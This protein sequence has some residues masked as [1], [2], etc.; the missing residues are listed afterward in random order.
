MQ[1]HSLQQFP[2]KVFLPT[3]FS[4]YLRNM[5]A[6]INLVCTRC[7]DDNHMALQRWYNDH[8]QL[9]MVSSELRAAALLRLDQTTASIN[10]LCLYQFADLAEF[11]AFDSGDVMRQVRDLSNAALGRSSVEIIKRTQYKRV[12]HRRWPARRC[13]SVQASLFVLSSDDLGENGLAKKS[14]AEKS[15]AEKSLAEAVRWLNDVLYALHLAQPLQSAEIYAAQAGEK[16]ELFVLLQS[17]DSMS[18]GSEPARSEPA[19]S[20][21]AK[22]QLASSQSI[23][24]DWHTMES[25]YAARPSLQLQWQAQGERVAQW[26]R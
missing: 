7:T 9:L 5:H 13:G 23:A 12:L 17:A 19:S 8:V 18:T 16:T 1:K 2:N 6:V 4:A 24:G 11:D 15:L 21:P 26:L 14:L 22:S 3:S 25:P 20:E 10:Y